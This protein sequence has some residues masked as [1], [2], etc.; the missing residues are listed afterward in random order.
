[1][2]CSEAPEATISSTNSQKVL[3][4]NSCCGDMPSPSSVS[5]ASGTRAKK[6]AL[7]M[8]SSAHRQQS[9]GQ[10]LLLNARRNSVDSATTPTVPQQ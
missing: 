9:T 5:L 6:I 2:P 10:L 4:A 3:L 1:M 8:G 7:P